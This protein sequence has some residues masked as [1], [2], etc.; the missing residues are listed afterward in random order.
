MEDSPFS[1]SLHEI[2]R[3]AYLKNFWLLTVSFLVA[4]TPA[5]LLGVSSDQKSSVSQSFAVEMTSVLVLI[6]GQNASIS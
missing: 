5:Y 4:L 2:F 1:Y 3:V 6:V